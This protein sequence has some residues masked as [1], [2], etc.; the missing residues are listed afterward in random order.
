MEKVL[1]CLLVFL[2]V[3]S[4]SYTAVAQEL[5]AGGWNVADDP[6]VTEERSDL[7]YKAL[8]KLVGV[9]YAPV[10]YLGSQSVAGINHCFLCLSRVVVPDA[11]PNYKLVFIYEDLQGNAE[12]MNIADFD[13]G[14]FCNY[15]A[16]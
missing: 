8:G 3:F 16:K 10:A 14:S 4:I 13:F 6:T 1:V 12:I 7:F 11:I 2:L 9:D 5:P 15:G